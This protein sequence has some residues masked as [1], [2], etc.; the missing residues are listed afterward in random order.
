MEAQ[1]LASSIILFP[2]FQV[3]DNNWSYF[4]AD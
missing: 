1:S 2:S 3:E 4:E